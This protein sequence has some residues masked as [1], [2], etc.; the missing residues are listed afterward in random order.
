MKSTSERNAATVSAALVG[1]NLSE[2]SGRVVD[3]MTI[4][5]GWSLALRVPGAHIAGARSVSGVRVGQLGVKLAT[6]SPASIRIRALVALLGLAALLLAKLLT[7]L[8]PLSEHE[9]LDHVLPWPMPAT[10]HA[11]AVS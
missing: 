10:H 1:A 4:S 5:S 6:T 7:R 8:A 11:P 9:A 2:V 3:A